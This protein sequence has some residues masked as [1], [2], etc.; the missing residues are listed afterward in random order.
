[1]TKDDEI[2]MVTIKR[3]TNH[4]G[5]EFTEHWTL[6]CKEGNRFSFKQRVVGPNGEV[7]K[8]KNISVDEVDNEIRDAFN[9]MFKKAREVL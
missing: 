2:C 6:K 1:M 3:H 7:C 9:G 4:W 8:R 5:S